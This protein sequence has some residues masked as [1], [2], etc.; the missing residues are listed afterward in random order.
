LSVFHTGK[1]LSEETRAFM[2]QAK[3]GVPLS[4]VYKAQIS[5]AKKRVP[6]QIGIKLP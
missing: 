1:T 2:S 4:D 5:E 6:Y 3:I